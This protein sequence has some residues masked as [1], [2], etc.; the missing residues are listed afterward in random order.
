MPR[1][2]SE[3]VEELLNQLI[4]EEADLEEIDNGERGGQLELQDVSKKSGEL[5]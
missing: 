3:I 1:S 2:P 5:E 4:E